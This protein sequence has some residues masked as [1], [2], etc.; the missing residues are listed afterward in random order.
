MEEFS[1]GQIALSLYTKTVFAQRRNA[2]D[3]I[4]HLR[5][6]SLSQEPEK[7]RDHKLTTRKV[8]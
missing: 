5:T 7:L 4:G 8:N 2:N 1:A 6:P 3:L